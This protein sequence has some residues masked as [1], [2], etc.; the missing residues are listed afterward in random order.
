MTVI[1]PATPADVDAVVSLERAVFDVAAWSPRS[2]EE[3]FDALSDGRRMLVALGGAGGAGAVGVIGYG[4]LSVAGEVADLRRIAVD[5]RHQRRGIATRLIA[6]LI[7]DARAQGCE[8]VLLEVAA[9]NVAGLM[10]YARLGF[11]ETDRRARYYQ[12]G[13]DAVVMRLDLAARPAA[14]RA[15]P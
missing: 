7:A 5:A 10:L 15:R 3:E 1:R 8:R 9:D 14:H 6:G 13:A 2:V 11:A 12:G 4:V